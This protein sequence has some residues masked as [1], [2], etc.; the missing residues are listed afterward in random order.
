MKVTHMERKDE[1]SE[2]KTCSFLIKLK[3]KLCEYV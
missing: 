3:S 1:R 2:N